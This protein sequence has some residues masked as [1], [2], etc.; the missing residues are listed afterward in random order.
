MPRTNGNGTV[1]MFTTAPSDY[2]YGW[3]HEIEAIAGTDSYSG[4]VYRRVE[5]DSKRSDGQ[6]MRYGS[7]LHAVV[8][9]TEF[10]KRIDL[11][12]VT[13]GGTADDRIFMHSDGCPQKYGD[14]D[15]CTCVLG[16]SL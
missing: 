11:G 2:D 9:A 8:D 1:T 4:K 12:L 16:V 5:I 10:A 3:T 13:F 6:C 15:P 14:D 7:G